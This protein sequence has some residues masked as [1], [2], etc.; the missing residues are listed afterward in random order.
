MIEHESFEE[1]DYPG[2][3]YCGYPTGMDNSR[4]DH[5]PIPAVCG[6]VEVVKACWSCH[7]L[8]D[9]LRLDAFV[10]YP[11]VLKEFMTGASSKVAINLLVESIR[12]E[13][14][15]SH[16]R[17]MAVWDSLN[18]SQRILIAR[19]IA[20]NFLMRHSGSVP[21]LSPQVDALIE[22]LNT[23]TIEAKRNLGERITDGIRIAQARGKTIGRPAGM[24]EDQIR[25]ARALMRD[26]DISMKQISEQLGVP[27]STL[28]RH[29][30]GGRSEHQEKP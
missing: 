24:T 29:L 15:V 2:C 13:P 21:V 4:G 25:M 16:Q 8:K 19:T 23:N 18:R 26:G 17:A 5:F 14:N 7:N 3:F 10:L 28:Y 22:C 20:L 6:G 1:D 9:N 30:P 12:L 11:E 27:R